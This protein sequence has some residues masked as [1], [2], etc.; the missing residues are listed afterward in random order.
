MLDNV[1]VYWHTGTAASSARIY[2]EDG[3]ARPSSRR[4]MG[5]PEPLH[6]PVA[7][8]VFPREQIRPSRRWCERVY[9]DL[10]FFSEPDRGGHF[11]AF[12]QPAIFVD[13]VRRASVRCADAEWRPVGVRGPG[14]STWSGLRPRDRQ[15]GA[16]LTVGAACPTASTS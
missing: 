5:Q 6:V 4:R 7:V 12:E 14:A 11:A 3:S 10:R 1:S 2:W 8:S 15:P 9:P 13:E 16:R